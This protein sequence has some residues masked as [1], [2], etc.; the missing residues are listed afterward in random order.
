MVGSLWL[1]SFVFKKG[2]R[3]EGGGGSVRVLRGFGGG[4]GVVG[5]LILAGADDG[6]GLGTGLDCDITSRFG[7]ETSGRRVTSL[8]LIIIISNTLSVVGTG[9]VLVCKS[10]C[11]LEN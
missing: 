6:R 8:V 1:V 4:G 11:G 9:V 5:H 10:C 3:G 2:Q 7:F